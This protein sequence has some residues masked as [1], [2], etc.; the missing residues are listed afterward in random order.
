VN[1][2]KR[3]AHCK[4]CG[5]VQFKITPKAGSV[6]YNCVDCNSEVTTISYDD[7]ET[8]LPKCNECGGNIFKV[9]IT[10]DEEE[11]SNECWNPECE[12]CK[13]APLSVYVNHDGEI[14]DEDE[15]EQLLIVKT[16]EDLEDE[17]NMK[18]EIIDQLEEELDN[19]TNEVEEKDNYIYH[20]KCELAESIN[21][22][23]ELEDHVAELE[24]KLRK[25]E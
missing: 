8:L 11:N 3:T 21:R 2:V 17:V 16:L 1:K 15:R 13:G 20:L 4:N 7:F 10:I 5:G 22:V 12:N 24:W 6:T 14:I 23:S 9:R 18:G 19:L 25:L